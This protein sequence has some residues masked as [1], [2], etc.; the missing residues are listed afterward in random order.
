MAMLNPALSV[1]KPEVQRQHPYL[2]S[3]P[4]GNIRVKLNQNE[5]PFDVPPHLRKKILNAWQEIAFNRYPLEQ[6]D[7]LARLIAK[8]IKWSHEGIIVGNG[9][10]ELT[11]TIG[12]AFVSSGSRVVLPRPMF[13]FYQRVAQIFGGEVISIPPNENLGFNVHG[14]LEAIKTRHPSVV[15]I[16]TPNNPTSLVVSLA[17]LQAIAKASSGL[18]LIDEAY[19]EFALEPSMLSVLKE[20][21]NVILL[22]T[23]SKAYG[24]A[25]LRIGYLIGD[26]TLMSEIMKVRL[27]FM[28]DRFSSSAAKLLLSHSDLIDDRIQFVQSETKKLTNSLKQIDGVDV[29][30]GQSNFVTFRPPGDQQ[31]IFQRLARMGVLVRDMSGYSELIGYLRVS[32]GTSDENTKFIK[33]L[34]M[35]LKKD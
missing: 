10:N 28:I 14:I 19:V 3:R 16:T 20:F 6:P 22:R 9:S 23:F 31:E 35:I 13:S 15:V 26:T 1:V 7:E 4:P 25:G 34:T 17:D 27:P 11:Y 33:A 24:L 5:L 2:V 29:L 30:E 8:H 32:T 18:V 21:P 12:L